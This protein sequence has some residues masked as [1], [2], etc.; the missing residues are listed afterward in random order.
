ME[1]ENGLSGNMNCELCKLSFENNV[2]TKLYYEDDKVIIVDDLHKREFKHRI[3]ACWKSHFKLSE[4]ENNDYNYLLS[5]LK[6]IADKKNENYSLDISNQTIPD[7]A[8]I[9]A[10][11]K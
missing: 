4:L 8:H 11:F 2:L 3:I 10:C 5:K 1:Q 7:H 9:Q 6:E